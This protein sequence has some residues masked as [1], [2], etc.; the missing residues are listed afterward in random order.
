MSR[1]QR[2]LGVQAVGSNLFSLGMHLGRAEHYRDLRVSAIKEWA[3]A[4]A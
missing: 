3:L 2:L 1:A 4:A